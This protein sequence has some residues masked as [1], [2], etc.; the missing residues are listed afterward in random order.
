MQIRGWKLWEAE[1]SSHDYEF[2]NGKIVFMNPF[3]FYLSCVF[4]ILFNYF[5]TNMEWSIIY[6]PDK[7]QANPR[8]V[9]CESSHEFLD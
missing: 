6:R 4:C 3:L 1:T 8:D 9:F 7:I 5:W 2:S